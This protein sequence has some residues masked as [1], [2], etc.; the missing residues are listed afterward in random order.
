[1]TTL[2]E[3]RVTAARMGLPVSVIEAIGM[4]PSETAAPTQAATHVLQPQ[5]AING[6][7]GG[8]GI[9]GSGQGLVQSFMHPELQIAPIPMGVV[10]GAG[11]LAIGAGAGFLG[12]LGGL[13]FGGGGKQEQQITQTPTVTP[14]QETPVDVNP[15][16]QSM[17][18]LFTLIQSR[19][20]AEIEIG[21]GSIIHG[22]VGTTRQIT[23]TYTYPT[24]YNIQRTYTITKPTQITKTTTTAGQ[25][26]KQEGSNLLAIAV[27]AIAAIIILPKLFKGGKK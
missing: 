26:A 21:A 7:D 8:G 22:D 16:L 12:L 20:G 24:T 2:F 1:M 9:P 5:A 11:K 25:E 14:T 10:S 3:Q 4:P 23:Q 19:A 15:V 6:N 18:K 17:L 27:A 13:L